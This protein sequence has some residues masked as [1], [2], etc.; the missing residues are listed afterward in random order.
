MRTEW[1]YCP[2]QDNCADPGRRGANLDKMEKVKWFN[3]LD[4]LFEKSVWPD[5]P[6]LKCTRKVSEEEKPLK[7]VAVY[8]GLSVGAYTLLGHFR[9]TVQI[10]RFVQNC[11][12][13]KKKLE[14]KKGPLCTE[15]ILKAREY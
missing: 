12:A 3:G 6:E 11:Q 5:Q 15:E 13:R 2:S 10:L 1:K 9:V 8:V 14:R 4:W 7:E